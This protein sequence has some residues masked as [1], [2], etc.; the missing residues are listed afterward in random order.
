MVSS[1]NFDLEKQDKLLFSVLENKSKVGLLVDN[2][3]LEGI[4]KD[5]EGKLPS[6][7][8]NASRLLDGVNVNSTAVYCQ[9]S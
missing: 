4:K 5:I 7:N 6:L 8:E 9:T 2:T 1:L 3:V